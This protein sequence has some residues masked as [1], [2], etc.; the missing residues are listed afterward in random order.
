MVRSYLVKEQAEAVANSE[1]WL[2]K[3]REI[4][5]AGQETLMQEGEKSPVPFMRMTAGH[6]R[7][8][9]ALCPRKVLLTE[10][11]VEPIPMEALANVGL[12]VKEGYFDK[13]E[14]WYADGDA[15]TDPIV[16]GTRGSGQTAEQYAVVQWGAE[17]ASE[18]RLHAIAKA[19]LV[20]Q[21]RAK[22]EKE[23]VEMQGDLA[24]LDSLAEG[25]LSGAPFYNWRLGWPSIS[26]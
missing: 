2:S 18:E 1:E 16:V 24:A 11:D 9:T 23:V 7:L 26:E 5:L 13:I 21:G 15:T 10:F 6:K 3:V 14:V 20:R 22:L 25:Y 17:D 12:A 4:G 19:R 8:F